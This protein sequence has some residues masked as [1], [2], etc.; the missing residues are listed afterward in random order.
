[1]RIEIARSATTAAA[2]AATR[3]AA[4]AR[5][6]VTSRGRFAVAFSGGS[7][8]APMFAALA[9][10]D[11]PWERIHVLQ[12]DERVAPDGHPE[13]N[14]TG[15]RRQLLDRIPIPSGNVHPMPVTEPD[16]DAAAATYAARI[17][18]LC[19]QPPRVDLVHLGLGDDG[20]TASLVPGDPILEVTDRDVAP[21]GAY[22]GHRRLTLTVPA[23]SRARRLLWLVTGAGKADAVRRLVDADETAP[24][25]RL[26]RDDAPLVLDP[27]AATAI[28]SASAPPRMI[29]R[30]PDV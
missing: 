9:D 13:R 18:G 1:M 3:I 17:A 4:A 8:P 30:R 25:A 14:L 28:S 22:R 23:L 26:L 7:T 24:A 19:G 21:T 27:P 10:H 6:D 12:V 15:L 5:E 16:L 2:Y 11:L 29:P 20:H